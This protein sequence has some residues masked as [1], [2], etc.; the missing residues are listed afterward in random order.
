MTKFEAFLHKRRLDS[1]DWNLRAVLRWQNAFLHRLV[2]RLDSE[3]ACAI[4]KMLK[5]IVPAFVLVVVI[6][7][8]SKPVVSPPIP[9]RIAP[10]IQSFAVSWP[11]WTDGMAGDVLP[12]V[13][14]RLAWQPEILCNGGWI[15]LTNCPPSVTNVTVTVP[16]S[17]TGAFNLDYNY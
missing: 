13:H 11:Q 4:R 2:D 6:G 9:T 8:V 15:L 7:C 16:Q 10:A 14:L 5:R 12:T 3:K 1:R 17:K